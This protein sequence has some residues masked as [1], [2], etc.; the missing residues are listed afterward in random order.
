MRSVKIAVLLLTTLALSTSSCC[1]KTP[2]PEV[3]HTIQ[4]DD[5][6]TWPEDCTKHE[7]GTWTC[8]ADTLSWV[9]HNMVDLFY[10]WEKAEDNAKHAEQKGALKLEACEADLDA[11]W[12]KWWF[13]TLVGLGSGA[14][15]GFGVGF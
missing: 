2:P 9:Y 14:A 5:L 13:W 3:K 7:D 8:K 11:I 12:C 6:T 10:D 4:E 15:I 1:K